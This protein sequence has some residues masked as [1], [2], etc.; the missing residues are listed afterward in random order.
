MA[1]ELQTYPYSCKYCN[2]IYS[3]V[4]STKH[5]F[6]VECWEKLPKDIRDKLL[7]SNEFIPR[8]KLIREAMSFLET[9]DQRQNQSIYSL[10]R[11]NSEMLQSRLKHIDAMVERQLTTARSDGSVAVVINKDIEKLKAWER[12]QARDRLPNTAIE[13]GDWVEG[14]ELAIEIEEETGQ[15]AKE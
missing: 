10:F 5:T 15:L 1:K 11:E 3:S 9:F 2:K 14:D 7:D 8:E 12:M 4:L 6:C 13:I